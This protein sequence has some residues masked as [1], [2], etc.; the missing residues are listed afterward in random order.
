MKGEYEEG[1]NSS[2]GNN[3]FA[4]LHHPHHQQQKLQQLHHVVTRECQ[5]SEE[6]ESR[7]SGGVGVGGGS[8]GGP[9]GSTAD[10]SINVKKIKKVDGTTAAGDGATIEVVRRPRGRPPG[11]KNKPKPP[12][13]I[14]RDTEC[15][16]RPQVLEVPGGLDVVDAISRFSRRRNLGVCVLSGSGTVANVTLRQPSTNPGATVTF[17]GRFDI[18]SISA[19]FLPPSSTSLPSSVNG[20]TISLAGP[21]GQ[22]LGGSVVGSLLAAGTVFIVAATFSNPSYH[23]LPLE[24]EVP[25]S[26]SGNAG[27]SPSPPGGG[28][29]SHPPPAESCGM[30]IYSCH[31]PSDVIW[32]PTARQPPPP[33][34]F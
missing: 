24:D 13:I 30:S 31:L 18:L 4:K 11:S 19:T 3:M 20:F 22:I 2:S 25:N 7:S 34:P 16:M 15:A 17:H 6:D 10:G 12:V 8:G 26:L 9:A 5:T 14:T 33:P 32:A 29:G 27:Q 23:R 21:Q 28:E 1:K